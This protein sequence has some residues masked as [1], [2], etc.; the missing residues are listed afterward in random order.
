MKDY[1]AIGIQ[2]ATE[3][4]PFI[5]LLIGG[6][7]A[8]AFWQICRSIS[9]YL[10]LKFN[11]YRER[12]EVYL[13]GARAVITKIGLLS[14]TFLIVNGGGTVMKWASVSNSQ[15]TAQRIERISLKLKTLEQLAD[16][17]CEEEKK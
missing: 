10:L 6:T 13:N 8:F 12:E 2:L 17:T 15:M 11:G 4:E 3:I 16:V 7:I 5:L 1:S 9:T 14:T